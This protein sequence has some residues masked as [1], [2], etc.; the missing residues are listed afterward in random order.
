M[1]DP[2]FI[3]DN[4]KIVRE[5]MKNRGYKDFAPLDKYLEKDKLW[6]EKLQK[7]E[8]LQIK[9]KEV[10]PKG[11][12]SSEELKKLKDISGK[13]KEKEEEA[14][15]YEEEAKKSAMWL[16]NIPDSSV[17]KGD[18]ESCNVEVRKWGN[19]IGREYQVKEHDAVG[20]DLDILDFERGTKI[21]GARFVLY[22]G[23]GSA[24][25]R[26]LINF[27]LDLHVEEHRFCE[28]ITPFLVN[29]KSITVTGQLPKF[30]ED[31]FIT[32]DNK[33]YLVPT[34]E[35]PVTN[36]YRDEIIE[37]KT[38]PIKFVSYTPC[39]RKEA[40]SYGKDVKGI[41]RQHQF[42]K[43]ELVYFSK[44]EDSYND[45]EKLTEEAESI[46][47]KLELPYRVVTLCMADLGFASAKTYDIEVWFE[48]QKR[49]REVSSCSNFLDFQARRG[50][51][52]YRPSK[53]EKTKYVHT[54]NG[55]GLAI[56]RTLAAILEYYQNED[57]TVSVPKVLQKYI[58]MEVIK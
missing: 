47:K 44:P 42:N 53:G 5:S 19:I 34:A 38:W 18:N 30:E 10:S 21:A 16:P 4:E 46:L 15:E 40:G 1:L 33:F 49:Y 24:L 26:A 43:V 6:R 31:L 20:Q 23:A 11:K 12:P 45:L 37:S 54:L 9:R 14:K 35:V 51:I 57:G 3:R 55:S 39:F 8:E 56:G 29:E 7:I 13:I 58:G 36:I 28:V 17:P 27:M 22:K 48:G 32:R 2:K 50:L 52:R 25:E 41:V